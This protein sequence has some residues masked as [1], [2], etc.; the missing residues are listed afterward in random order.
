MTEAVPQLIHEPEAFRAA[1]DQARLQGLRVALVP[2]MGAL[3]RGHMRLIE[4]ARKHGSFV[5]VSVFVNPTQFGPTE[6][7]AS[8]PRT[9][10]HDVEACR[11]A[12][13]SCVFAPSTGAMYPSGEQTR[14]RVMGLSEPMCGLTRPGHVEGVATVVSKLFA[15]TGPCTAVFGRKDYQQLQVLKRMAADMMFPVRVVGV[16]TVREADGLAMSSRNA[17]LSPEQRRQAAAIPQALSRA[18]RAFEQGERD[19]GVLGA[20]VREGIEPVAQSI[21]YVHVGDPD[22][23]APLHARVGER[24]LIAV[25]LRLGPARLIDNV[26]LGEDAAPCSKETA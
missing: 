18:V 6:D 23:L 15:L 21:D 14:V 26:V 22:T 20:M 10:D 16:P 17:Y 8:Y 11:Q 9:L 3:H 13:A 24:A 25:A 5:A 19:A 1:C 7:F 12:G 2:T 4:E